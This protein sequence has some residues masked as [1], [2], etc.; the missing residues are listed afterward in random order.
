MTDLNLGGGS[1]RRGPDGPPPGGLGVIVF[2]L[3]VASVIAYGTGS[4][5][6]TSFFAFAASVPLGIYAATTYARLL[7]LGIRVP[8]PG[9][10]FFGGISASILLGIS[11]LLGW[12]QAQVAGLPVAVS[13]FVSELAF[14]L[15]GVGFATGLGLL[16]AGIAVP[17]V[18]LRLLPRW[19]GWVGLVL[20]ALGEIAFLSLLWSGLDVLLPV[21]RFGGLIWLAAVGFLL[22]RTRHDIPLREREVAR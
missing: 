2:V 21:V 18:V 3:T 6:W 20:G 17:S 15:G 1:A 11:G 10:S 7:R 13:A 5:R 9:I 14:A 4:G 19:L 12:A 16:M 8:G 22:P